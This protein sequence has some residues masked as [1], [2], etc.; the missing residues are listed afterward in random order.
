MIQI[1]VLSSGKIVYFKILSEY[2]Y[3]KD[4]VRYVT[5]P[6]FFSSSYYKT[7]F[8]L[9]GGGFSHLKFEV[10]KKTFMERKKWNYLFIIRLWQLFTIILLLGWWWGHT[11]PPLHTASH[12]GLGTLHV[13]PDFVAHEGGEGVHTSAS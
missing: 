5:P 6:N 4:G 8:F 2:C 7:S 11:S 3:Y 10:L 1:S 12:I 13:L 9:G